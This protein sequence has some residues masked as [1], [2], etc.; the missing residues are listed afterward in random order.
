V[1][2]I[3]IPFVLA[4]LLVL[5]AGIYIG[6]NFQRLFGHHAEIPSENESARTY[7]K[8][9]VIL[10]WLHALVLTGLFALGLGH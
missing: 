5:A 10:I 6:L 7:T 9:M 1:S 3:Q 2:P 4:F 8:V